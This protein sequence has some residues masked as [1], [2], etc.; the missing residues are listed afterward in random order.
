MDHRRDRGVGDKTAKRRLS[1]FQG[2]L[3]RDIRLFGHDGRRTTWCR[4][5]IADTLDVLGR[6]DEALIERSAVVS[7]CSFHLGETNLQTLYARLARIRTL[8]EC[9]RGRD[10]AAEAAEVFQI[11]RRTFGPEHDVTRKAARMLGHQS[12]I[13]GVGREAGLGSKSTASGSMSYNET[14]PVI[15][16]SEPQTHELGHD[17]S[18]T[19]PTGTARNRRL[20]RDSDGGT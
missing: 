7:A 18:E 11:G 17:R 20:K 12:F 5:D 1:R 10:A 16:S 4:V 2:R 13:E 19:S 8:R 15:R 14:N 3:R 9:T 6:S